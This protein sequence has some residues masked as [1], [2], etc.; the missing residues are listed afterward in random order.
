MIFLFEEQSYSRDTL[1]NVLSED[2]EGFFSRERGKKTVMPNCVGYY[3][4]SKFHQPVYILPKV[5]NF[6]K[7]GSSEQKAFGFIDLSS[8]EPL[9]SK[10]LKDLIEEKKED[11]E[12][13]HKWRYDLL[14][15]MPVFLYQA[16]ER[17]R[18]STLKESKSAYKEKT[19]DIESSK[20]GINET[21]LI[22]QCH[23]LIH[24]YENN[25][26]L[27]T[28][29]YKKAHS[30][31]NKVN[32]GKTVRTVQPIING[33]SVV[34]PTVYNLRKGINYDEEL[35]I[36]LFS[37][38]RYINDEYGYGNNVESL[39]SLPAKAV[40]KQ[41]VEQRSVS[42]KLLKIKANYSNDTMRKLWHMLY[43]LH[44][45]LDTFNG[46]ASDKEEFLFVRSFNN[47]FEKM[48]D[49]LMG[50]S[51]FPQELKD[52]KDGKI[53]DHIIKHS[54]LPIAD[55]D[56][57]YVGDSKYYKDGATPEGPSRYKQ[58]TYAKNIV[59][60]QMNWY[61]SKG[62]KR[63]QYLDYRDE[64]TEGYNIT[65]N[66]FIMGMVRDDYDYNHHKLARVPFDKKR[67]LDSMYQFENRLFDRDTLFLMQYSINFMF[68][69]KAYTTFSSFQ[70]A[71][72]KDVAKNEFRKSFTD[73]INNKYD[74]RILLLKGQFSTSE[75]LILNREEAVNTTF[76]SL[77]GKIYCPKYLETEEKPIPWM[78]MALEKGADNK[79]YIEAARTK[80]H[81]IENYKLGENPFSVIAE[82]RN[83]N[84]QFAN[85]GLIILENTV[86]HD[87]SIDMPEAED[88][89]C[90]MIEE[91]VAEEAK[92]TIF[93]PFFS[94]KAACV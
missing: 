63:K 23:S 13:K 58:F 42:K 80:F 39:Y 75:E 41:Q 92:Y 84:S 76:R 38:L 66:F 32:W 71:E 56:I 60:A 83:R 15:K 40:F 8:E 4:S 74:F 45:E 94:I 55:K 27:I 54:S 50:D 28:L 62:E 25:Q 21:S 46:K 14:M 43:A 52:Q 22:D 6:I 29:V 35:M 93:L 69:L 88:P 44:S 68:V 1:L 49:E 24:F 85:E 10:K 90:W 16:I 87:S 18:V 9:N 11:G 59:Q 33:D 77:I 86:S 20:K 73:S 91:E 47:V 7:E 34:Y 81:L 89:G 57:Y 72:F 31:Y 30:G 79:I 36:I 26:N 2:H 12:P 37:T 51:D 82:W 48:I 78:L 19:F 17:Y 53:I 67:N 3:F 5:F 64:L 70:K 61:H 65:P